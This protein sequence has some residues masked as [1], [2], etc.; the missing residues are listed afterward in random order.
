MQA[1]QL[2]A[3]VSEQWLGIE[4]QPYDVLSAQ[5]NM[6]H[7][8]PAD[9]SIL[10]SI[11]PVI[12]EHID[13]IVEAFYQSVIS[14]KALEQMITDNSS[15]DRLKVTLQQH[16]IELFDG[17]I[18]NEF[19]QKRLRIADIHLRIGLEPKWYMG[20]FHNLQNAI[21]DVI[22]SNIRDHKECLILLKAICKLLNFEQQLV[23]EAYEQK[24][25]EQSQKHYERVKRELKGNMLF[26]TEEL[27]ALTEQTSASVQQLLSTSQTVYHSATNSADKAHNSKSL[28]MT[29]SSKIKQ[30]SEQMQAIHESSH[31][32]GQTIS[33]LEFTSKQI[34]Q[35]VTIV[36]Q[37]SNQIKI[38]SLNAAIEAA[39][40]GV[41]GKGFSVV[42]D[43]I[44][45]LS[46]DTRHSLEQIT[47]FIQHT[48]HYT[49]QVID[50]IHGVQQLISLGQ[51]GV[52][53]TNEVFTQIF[54]SLDSSITDI[55]KVKDEVSSLV[56]AVEVI[57][58]ATVKVAH[59][60]ESLNQTTQ[61]L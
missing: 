14:V 59:S 23:L 48:S 51:Q 22:F 57:G 42:A 28:A 52:S 5:M 33:Q 19:I 61:N 26:V 60:T 50:S 36:A 27:A 41:H 3:V 47:E 54:S 20:A 55:E 17:R 11:Q 40:A 30:L 38:L 49:V 2:Q 13:H 56:A 9:L 58:T 34:N 46:E 7:L 1:P 18:D 6:V 24:H 32:M 4:S 53:E 12:I 16:T 31:L 45:K 8:T 10:R 39:R 15:L 21:M 29:G 43:E 35:I 44:R 37:I 25:R